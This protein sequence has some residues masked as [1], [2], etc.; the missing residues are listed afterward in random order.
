MYLV[1]MY[2][3]STYVITIIIN[4]DLFANSE[5][6]TLL[7]SSTNIVSIRNNC[8]AKTTYTS[9]LWINSHIVKV[10]VRKK[11][12]GWFVLRNSPRQRPCIIGIAQTIVVSNLPLIMILFYTEE[13][14]VWLCIYKIINVTNST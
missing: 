7:E 12:L 10:V 2:N 5:N 4:Y 6:P 1:H 3:Y 14:V 9:I 8:T 11:C 13:R